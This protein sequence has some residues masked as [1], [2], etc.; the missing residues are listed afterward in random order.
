M[1]LFGSGYAR[2]RNRRAVYSSAQRLFNEKGM[3]VF[4][5]VRPP[6]FTKAFPKLYT[7]A[8]S[9]AKRVK[10]K[11]VEEDTPGAPFKM[12]IT[13]TNAGC[14]GGTPMNTTEPQPLFLRQVPVPMIDDHS[15]L[16]TAPFRI[17]DHLLR[18]VVRS[19][20]RQ[21]P[22]RTNQQR[23]PSIDEM[24]D[25]NRQEGTDLARL[26]TAY[27]AAW[28]RFTVEV[29]RSQ[30]LQADPNANAISTHEAERA[31]RSAEDQYRQARNALADY[32]L[33]RSSRESVL[34]GCR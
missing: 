24:R 8:E 28:R 31:A 11:R 32:I 13:L 34:A 16:I 1:F 10:S 9:S 22:D 23:H 25:S 4:K 20:D 14:L 6:A 2:V 33:E 27:E 3:I 19:V 30:S 18:P 12:R 5:S 29:T 26:R 21:H 7:I 17:T 15:R